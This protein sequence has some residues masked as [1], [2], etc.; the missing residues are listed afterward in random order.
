MLDDKAEFQQPSVSPER[1]EREGTMKR[2]LAGLV[3]TM[4]LAAGWSAVMA[5]DRLLKRL[6][7]EERKELEAE[8]KELASAGVKHLQGGKLVEATEAF[9]KAL[10]TARRLYPVTEFR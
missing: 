6:T 10:E 3:L 5:E 7:P 4:T 8:G 2:G 1:A 9:E